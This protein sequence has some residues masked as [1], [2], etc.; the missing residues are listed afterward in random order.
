M[1]LS[2]HELVTAPSHDE[3]IEGKKLP[4][5]EAIAEEVIDEGNEINRTGRKKDMVNGLLNEKHILYEDYP[6]T[7]VLIV[8]QLRPP[9]GISRLARPICDRQGKIGRVLADLC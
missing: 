1:G 2:A 5:E 8:R 3:R 6:L 9:R 4:R 7:G